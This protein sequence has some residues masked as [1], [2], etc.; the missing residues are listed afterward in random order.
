MLEELLEASSDEGMLLYGIILNDDIVGYYLCEDSER[1]KY[2]FYIT[3]K[4]PHMNLKNIRDAIN[5]ILSA[6]DGKAL[7]LPVAK[8]SE[9]LC[10]N[11]SVIKTITMFHDLGFIFTEYEVR[12]D[13]IAYGFIIKG[14]RLRE[15]R[16]G[17]YI[18]NKYHAMKEDGLVEIMRLSR[19]VL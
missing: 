14:N 1:L 3:F 6:V 16:F 13:G 18:I 11:A 7:A 2:V 19:A 10:N 8:E 12:M 4:N 9:R 17:E 5:I 15:V